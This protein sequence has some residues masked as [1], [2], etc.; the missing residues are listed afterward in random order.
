MDLIVSNISEF[1]VQNT[2]LYL[3]LT[4]ILGGLFIVKYSKEFWKIKDVH[5]VLI[6]SV[7]FSM[8]FYM[9]DECKSGCIHKY[10]FTY[11]LTTSF[12]ETILK[13]I[14]SKITGSFQKKTT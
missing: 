2:D 10:L 6:A 9:L 5:K 4:I 3:M 12:Y 8:I 14:M 13:W 7:V 11:L 1:V